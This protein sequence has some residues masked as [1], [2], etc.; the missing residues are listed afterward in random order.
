[1]IAPKQKTAAV[2]IWWFAFG[3][4]AAYV[5]YSALTKHLS[6]SKGIAGFELLPITAIASF[7]AMIIF[8]SAMGWWKHAGRRKI[9]GISVPWPGKWTFL[10][11]VC[12][13]AIIP[14]TTLAYTFGGISIV[15]MML[16]LR[17]GVLALA[18]I[19][20]AIS[21]RRVR[22]FSW[23]ALALTGGSLFVSFFFGQGSYKMTVAA[24]IDLAVYLLAYFVRLRFMSR[25]AKSDD[26]A[27]TTRYFVEEHMSATPVLLLVLGTFAIFGQG[28]GAEAVSRGFTEFFD[29]G[30]AVVAIAL[31][32]GVLSEGTGIF[33]GLV[34]LG[35]Q[36]N[37]YCVPVNR[38]SSLL[39]GVTASFALAIFGGG[40]WPGA[41]EL[42]GAGMIIFAI[43]VLSVGPALE[44]RR[45]A[46][47]PVPASEAAPAQAQTAPDGASETTE[48]M[49]KSG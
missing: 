19:V 47:V 27:A 7:V 16:L 49:R 18:P 41:P 3:Y 39:A 34:L 43:V 2:S 36:E 30:A 14:T 35:K 5:P 38:A 33:G 26:A 45:K 15:F 25:L 44:K 40:R 13:A 1:M 48:P 6:K 4:F 31:L 22:W 23:I 17:G 46:A 12:S 29:H 42:V 8:L 11:G 28:A 9:L 10:S 32:I 37:T 20:D 24:G 21:G